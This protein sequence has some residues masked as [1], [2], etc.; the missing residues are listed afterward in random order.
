MS[1]FFC[2]DVSRMSSNLAAESKK[3]STGGWLVAGGEQPHW[4]RVSHALH[5]TPLAS[6][7]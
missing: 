4:A 5:S 7:W 3:S 6:S 2:A 1:G